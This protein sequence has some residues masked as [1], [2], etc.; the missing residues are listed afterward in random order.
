MSFTR[1]IQVVPDWDFCINQRLKIAAILQLELQ[2]CDYL[3]SLRYTVTSG[4]RG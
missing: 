2:M 3:R 4:L 1:D